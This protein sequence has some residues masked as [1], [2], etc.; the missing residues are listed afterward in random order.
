MN[1]A[2]NKRG[3]NTKHAGPV[4]K[5][6]CIK[7]YKKI[8]SIDSQQ[9]YDHIYADYVY[10]RN[11]INADQHIPRKILFGSACMSRFISYSMRIDNMWLN[12][13]L[14][15]PINYF[16]SILFWLFLSLSLPAFK[17][18]ARAHKQQANMWP[19]QPLQ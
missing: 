10:A 6:N 19:G 5:A 15:L 13:P 18:H 9:R 3:Q 14:Q 8:A 4:R 12:V 1:A 7:Q 17:M 11:Q 16:I 2:P